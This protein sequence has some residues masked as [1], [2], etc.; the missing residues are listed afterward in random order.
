M[1][2]R[3]VL[4]FVAVVAAA[5]LAVAF[6]DARLQASGLELAKLP[7]ERLDAATVNEA[8]DR[9][10]RARLLNPDRTLAYHRGVLLLRTDRRAEGVRRIERYLR[11]EPDNRE[12]W[13]I[14]SAATVRTQ[15]ALSRRALR[16]FRQ[17]GST[18]TR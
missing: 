10:R 14:L 9:L 15:P 18:A 11:D 16:R 8:D 6:R 3:I 2:Q 5:W 12:A 17:L 7:V 1:A 4:A 13:G